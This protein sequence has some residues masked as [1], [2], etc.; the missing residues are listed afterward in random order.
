MH[1]CKFVHS[2]PIIQE[3]IDYTGIR[4]VVKDKMTYCL[5]ISTINRILKVEIA[6]GS[7]P[8]CFTRHVTKPYKL[9]QF[10]N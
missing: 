5:I 8:C 10:L 1:V 4:M 7:E 3:T 2:A 6:N 9:T